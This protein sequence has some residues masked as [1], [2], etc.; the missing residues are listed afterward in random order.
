MSILNNVNRELVNL[1]PKKSK[2]ILIS[3]KEDIDGIVSAALLYSNLRQKGYEYDQI[4]IHLVDYT[5]LIT[6]FETNIE[7]LKNHTLYIADMGINEKLYALLLQLPLIDTLSEGIYRYYYDHHVINRDA[8]EIRQEIRKRFHVYE[9]PS[10]NGL[11]LKCCTAE[12]IYTSLIYNDPHYQCLC[13]Y[14]HIADF[15]KEGDG[16]HIKKANELKM[17]ITYYQDTN[18]RLVDL[19]LSMQTIENWKSYYK[20]FVHDTEKIITWYTMQYKQVEKNLIHINGD[21]HT[22]LI[23]MADLKSEDIVYHMM[24]KVPGY[25]IYLGFSRRNNYANIQTGLNIAHIIASHFG[26]GGHPERAGFKI[27]DEIQNYINNRKFSYILES[28]FIKQ[29]KFYLKEY[30]VMLAQK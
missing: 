29:I 13:E 21:S 8:V 14:A 1:N 28:D 18:S 12:I 7:E 9:N 24:K 4:D 10:L 3:H 11:P 16:E 20:L 27:P 25:D 23:S 17:F 5:S 2:V 6:F 19:L 26:G 22:I 30:L 15:K